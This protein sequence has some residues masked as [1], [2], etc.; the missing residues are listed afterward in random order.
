MHFG[1]LRRLL[2]HLQGNWKTKSTAILQEMASIFKK[3]CGQGCDGVANMSGVYSGE[4]ARTREKEPLGI[5]VY[6]A[7]HNLNLVLKE[8]V[9]T[10]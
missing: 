3:R 10:F 9:K 5:Y 8:A 7:T 1:D 6:C 2:I 4:Q